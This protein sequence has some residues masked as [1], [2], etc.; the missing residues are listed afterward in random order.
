MSRGE[1]ERALPLLEAI[2]KE[3][4][5]F[6][7]AHVTLA[8]VYYRLK[9]REDGDR[10]RAI[11]D[12]LNKAIQAKQPGAVAPNAPPQTCVI[13]LH[14]L[15]RL[16]DVRTT[17]NLDDQLMAEAMALS[18]IAEKTQV[19]HEALRSLIAREAGRRLAKLGET[20]PRASAGRRRRSPRVR[21]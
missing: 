11:V 19:L 14:R 4:P 20:L 10:E 16:V 5:K 18:G 21:P 8:T 6:L 17:L 2:V 15:C 1:T 3:A 12:R 7:E 13:R 9:R